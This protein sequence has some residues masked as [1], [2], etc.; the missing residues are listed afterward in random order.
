MHTE[1]FDWQ[2]PG[3]FSQNDK[4]MQVPH[5][6]QPSPSVLERDTRRG[7]IPMPVILPHVKA[8]DR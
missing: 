1:L 8:C 4:S 7:G 3:T 6:P 2:N 5:Y